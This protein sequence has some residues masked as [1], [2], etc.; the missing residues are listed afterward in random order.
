[1]LPPSLVIAATLGPIDC[2]EGCKCW[3]GLCDWREQFGESGYSGGSP[4][5]G[6]SS[7]DSGRISEWGSDMKGDRL[8]NT[9]LVAGVGHTGEEGEDA[10]CRRGA[11]IPPS[12]EFLSLGCNGLDQWQRGMRSASL[13]ITSAASIGPVQNS[14]SSSVIVTG[15]I[16]GR[17]GGQET[18]PEIASLRWDSRVFR[19]RTIELR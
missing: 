7:P 10:G 8:C 9:G 6:M 5:V 1:V 16:E 11:A 3:G 13:G 12:S 17:L 2:C 19:E 4:S 14:R 18:T 15:T